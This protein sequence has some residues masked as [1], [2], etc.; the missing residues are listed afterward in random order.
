MRRNTFTES[1]HYIYMYLYAT[2]GQDEV[3][4]VYTLH[5]VQ[6]IYIYILYDMRANVYTRA[7]H[8]ARLMTR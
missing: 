8:P 2:Y 5:T 4:I 3:C 6:H 1:V 7:Q